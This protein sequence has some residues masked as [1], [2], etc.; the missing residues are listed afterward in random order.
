MTNEE[1]IKSISQKGEEWKDIPGYEG[2]YKVSTLGRVVS[3]HRTIVKKGGSQVTLPTCLL[4]INE[5]G[6]G[7]HTV[8]LC[9]NGTKLKRFVHRIVAITFLENPDNKPVVDHLNGDKTDN[10]LCNLKWAT[11]SENQCNEITKAR[12]R[13]VYID[14]GRPIVQLKNGKLIK[15]YPYQSDVKQ[16]GFQIANV[17][18]ACRHE[19]ASYKGYQW[20]YVDEYNDL[21][22]KDQSLN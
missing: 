2:M 4:R 7:Y 13:Q 1:F 6:T 21:L 17:A 10:R 5:V 16:H 14:R 15:I 11:Y 18:H 20:M 22:E 3:L 12:K 19:I 8:M 9:K